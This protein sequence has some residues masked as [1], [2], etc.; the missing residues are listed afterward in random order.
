MLNQTDEP[1]STLR[2]THQS[3]QNRSFDYN[4]FKFRRKTLFK[5]VQKNVFHKIHIFSHVSF[6]PISTKLTPEI[7][8]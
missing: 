6:F 1:E 2:D 7:V 5:T 8:Y 3:E 4:E